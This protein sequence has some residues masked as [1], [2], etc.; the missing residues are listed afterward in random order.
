MEGVKAMESKLTF[1]IELQY[2]LGDKKVVFHDEICNDGLST[3]LISVGNNKIIEKTINDRVLSGECLFDGITCGY[4]YVYD[5][6]GTTIDLK[7]INENISINESVNRINKVKKSKDFFKSEINGLLTI[8]NSPELISTPS[9]NFTVCKEITL[10]DDKNTFVYSLKK[11]FTCSEK[12]SEIES[13]EETYQIDNDYVS[14]ITELKSNTK[15]VH[16]N[17][18]SNKTEVTQEE[19]QSIIEQLQPLKELLNTSPK[20]HKDLK[21]DAQKNNTKKNNWINHLRF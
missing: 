4:A 8:T 10:I 3:K 7:Q 18:K 15:T 12:I 13:E 1:K 19:V 5:E 16:Y 11:N 2:F 21:I 9:K 17:I 14:I 20:S 6:N